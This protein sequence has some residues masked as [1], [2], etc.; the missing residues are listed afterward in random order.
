MRSTPLLGLVLFALLAGPA[1][2]QTIRFRDVTKSAGLFEPLA[3]IMGHGGAWGDFD[4]D[5]HLDLFV[6]GFCDR[7]DGEYLPHKGPVPS[8]LFRNLGNGKFEPV[9]DTPASFFGRTSGAVF[10]DLDNDG[11]LELYAA[12]NARPA[13]VTGTGPQAEAKKRFSNLFR[14]DRGKLI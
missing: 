10:A 13:R 2:G 8:R 6:G 9:K 5:G 1:G 14:N 12:N 4:G 11:F 7:P 3:G